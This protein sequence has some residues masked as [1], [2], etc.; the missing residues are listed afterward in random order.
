[1]K[2]NRASLAALILALAMVAASA[3]IADHIFERMPHIEDEFAL[4]W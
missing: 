1:M 3:Y 2:L 4:I